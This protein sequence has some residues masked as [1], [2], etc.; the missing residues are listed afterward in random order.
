LLKMK[1]ELAHYSYAIKTP[2]SWLSF[3]AVNE[4]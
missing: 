4:A 1:F 3:C 2:V